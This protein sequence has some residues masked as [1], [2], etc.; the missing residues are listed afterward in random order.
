MTFPFLLFGDTWA[1]LYLY[2]CRCVAKIRKV[3]EQDSIDLT[4]FATWHFESSK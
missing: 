3:T 2:S 4:C 1:T